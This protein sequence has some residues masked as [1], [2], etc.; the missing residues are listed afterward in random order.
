MPYSSTNADRLYANL[1]DDDGCV[2]QLNNCAT[3]GIDSICAAADHFCLQYI[4]N[5]FDAATSRDEYD[6]RQLAPDP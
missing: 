1:Y 3:S 5:F 2:D 4:E 6:I